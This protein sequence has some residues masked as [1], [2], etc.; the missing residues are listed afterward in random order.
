MPIILSNKSMR[1]AIL[2]YIFFEKVH[3]RHA[4]SDSATQRTTVTVKYLSYAGLMPF[5]AALAG[6][7]ILDD[8]PRGFSMLALIAYAAVI[9]SFVGAVHW[10]YVLSAGPE[11]APLLLSLSTAPNLT[12]WVSL[13]LTERVAL[14]VLALSFPLLLLYE[15]SSGLSRILP[16]WYMSMRLR[17]TCIVTATLVIA[18]ISTFR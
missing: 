6:L 17:L 14:L 3:T 8:A 1:S 13:L 12:A 7:L 15:K 10:G 5:I 16:D 4:M 9:L 11:H 18:L 2:S